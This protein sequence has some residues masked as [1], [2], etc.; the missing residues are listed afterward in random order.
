MKRFCAWVL[1]SVLFLCSFGGIAYAENNNIDV[2]VDGVKQDYVGIT[3]DGIP[4][5]PMEESFDSIGIIDAEYFRDEK[6]ATA[7]CGE[8]AVEILIGENYA[9]VHLVPIELSAPAYDDNG[10]MMIPAEFI[11]NGLS[12]TYSYDSVE[13]KI[14]ITKP[15]KVAP[16]ASTNKDAY[17]KMLLENAKAENQILEEDLEGKDCPLQRG[18]KGGECADSLSYELNVPITSAPDES[19]LDYGISLE[20]TE[21]IEESYQ[22]QWC[23]GV[24]TRPGGADDVKLDFNPGDIGLVSFWA[25]ALDWGGDESGV[26][27]IWFDVDG[28]NAHNFD[29]LGRQE[30]LIGEEWKQYY[31]PIYLLDENS[32]TSFLKSEIRF[33]FNLGFNKQTILLTSL[34]AY[35]LEG[36]TL[37]ELLSDL[38][39]YEGMEEDALWRKEALRR[40]DKYRMNDFTVTVKDALGNPI[41]DANVRADM[42]KNEFLFGTCIESY[43]INQLD[44][45]DG[46]KYSELI[47][48]NFNTIV[49]GKTKWLDTGEDDGAQAIRL[50]NWAYE[51]GLNFKG[52][53]AFWEGDGVMPKF[54][55]GKPRYMN[56]A[57]IYDIYT[58]RIAECMLPFKGKAVQWDIINEITYNSYDVWKPHG[59]EIYADMFKLAHEIDPECKLYI[60]ETGYNGDRPYNSVESFKNDKIKALQDLGAEI[61]GVGIQGHYVRA[62]YPQMIYNELDS[63]TEYTDE[64]TITEYDLDPPDEAVSAPFLRDMLILTYS[65][66]KAAGFIMWGFTDKQH[67]KANAPLYDENFNPKPALA[68]WQ[69]LVKDEWM[70]HESGD[71][72]LK[73]QCVFRGHRGDYI[74]TVTV[75]ENTIEVPFKLVESG[76]NKIIVTLDGDGMSAD[77]SNAPSGP[78]EKI[79]EISYTAVLENSLYPQIEMIDQLKPIVTEDY[80]N[81]FKSSV[82]DVSRYSS[83]AEW[84]KGDSW[85]T[86]KSQRALFELLINDSQGINFQRVDGDRNQTAFAKRIWPEGL[87]GN[88]EIHFEFL[89]DRQRLDGNENIELNL[90]LDNSQETSGNKRKVLYSIS[91]SDGVVT[92]SYFGTQMSHGSFCLQRNAGQSQSQIEKM[93]ISLIPRE[94]GGYTGKVKITN[95]DGELIYE[96]QCDYSADVTSSV[97]M[98]SEIYGTD[99]LRWEFIQNSS[100]TNQEVN[101]I[102][103]KKL[104]IYTNEQSKLDIQIDDISRVSEDFNHFDIPIF[105]DNTTGQPNDWQL[106][107]YGDEEEAQTLLSSQSDRLTINSGVISTEGAEI[108]SFLSKEFTPIE[109]GENLIFS[110]DICFENRWADYTHY[111][112]FAI[113]LTNSSNDDGNVNIIKRGCGEN[114]TKLFSLGSDNVFGDYSCSEDVLQFKNNT[115]YSLFAILRSN[116]Q[117]GYNIHVILSDMKSGEKLQYIENNV[118]SYDDARGLDGICIAARTKGAVSESIP[119]TSVR[120]LK[121]KTKDSTDTI[122]KGINEILFSIDNNSNED[123][124]VSIIRASKKNGVLVDYVIERTHVKAGES[125]TANLMLVNDGETVNELFIQDGI[126]NLMPKTLKKEF[127][128]VQ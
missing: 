32:N 52:H 110:T 123:K 79:D 92:E 23:V 12:G 73:G 49:P 91:S 109:Q 107:L 106:N 81:S 58:K 61:D 127:G 71:T 86:L 108:S 103:I 8:G 90:Y 27:R 121:L 16:D 94:N 57:E 44:T 122:R 45:P 118:I 116:N 74:I 33:V 2:Y 128:T 105:D 37:D 97:T 4:F 41:S 111:T 31:M 88:E 36:V 67:W 17:Y 46:R 50:A 40:I 47:L 30:F 112:D 89:L 77:V 64:F 48:E 54:L 59:I 14:F 104:D 3:S 115:W 99:M 15:S 7:T 72:D 114:G 43:G 95:L 56:Y 82:I 13:N 113:S 75:G 25:K 9:T 126:D 1:I 35:K 29:V 63:L 42:T 87:N 66:P 53:T 26:A 68:E 60:N 100:N 65:H 84:L 93:H 19:I 21:K 70:T 120:N 34:K 20:T 51:N 24:T 98:S 96:G 85:G 80:S 101:I 28:G 69:R 62:I 10:V 55:S 117:N 38:K 119:L 39:V 76:S 78:C 22:V 5:L 124:T 18:Y 83:D 102:G 6:K 11:E 125:S